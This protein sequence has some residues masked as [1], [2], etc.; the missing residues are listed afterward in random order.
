MKNLRLVEYAVALGRHRNFARAAASLGVTQPTFSRGIAALE[1]SIGARLFERTTRRV[2]L[3]ATGQAFLERANALL[4]QAASLSQ[5]TDSNALSLTGQLNIASGPYPLEISVL[6]AVARLAA[7]HPKLRMRVI[8]GAWKELPGMLLMGSVEVLVIESSVFTND[9]RADVELLPRH[10]AVLVCRSGHPLSRLPRVTLEDLERYPLAGITMGRDLRRRLGNMFHM[11]NVDPLNGDI[12]PQIATTSLKAMREIVRRTDGVA[13]CP[14]GPLE[15]DLR[16]GRLIQL[17][18]N[19][20]LPSTAYGMA[21]LRG[22]SLSSAARAF[23]Q[24]LREVEQELTEQ[25][26]AVTSPGRPRSPRR[27]ARSQR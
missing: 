3:T 27:G 7:L 10:Q 8:E 9:S 6:P 22:H 4:E 25:Q 12:L 15:A 26:T 1:K 23:M 5:L 17:E 20:D 19:I 13:L 21:T 2:E 16:A 11:L 24:T 14:R 18:S